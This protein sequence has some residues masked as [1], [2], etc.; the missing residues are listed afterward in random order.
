[1]HLAGPFLMAQKVHA[2]IPSGSRA[3]VWSA[4]V[5]WPQMLAVVHTRSGQVGGHAL[6]ARHM[7]PVSRTHFK[8]FLVLYTRPMM[9]KT[10]C[11]TNGGM[12]CL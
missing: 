5:L 2:A 3:G 4:L 1:M 11:S 9:R 6:S 7:V 10:H 12:V 8:R